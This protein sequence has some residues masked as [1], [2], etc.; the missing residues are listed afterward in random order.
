[1]TVSEIRV[2]ASV[3]VDEIDQR[4]ANRDPSIDVGRLIPQLITTIRAR[5]SQLT[6]QSGTVVRAERELGELQSRFDELQVEMTRERAVIEAVRLYRASVEP[7][8]R[9]L[10]MVLRDFD[11][12]KMVL[13]G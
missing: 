8:L 7:S 3:E 9:A 2:L 4:L 12:G 5:D 10:E 1:M 6:G 11:A 13:G